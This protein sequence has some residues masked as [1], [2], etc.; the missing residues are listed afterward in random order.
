MSDISTLL[1][2]LKTTLAALTVTGG[3]KAFTQILPSIDDVTP[4]TFLSM[5]VAVIGN[6]AVNNDAENPEL[7][8]ELVWIDI[9]TRD[10]ST[11]G[12]KQQ[13]LG[14]R[15]CNDLIQIVRTAVAHKADGAW[16]AGFRVSGISQPAKRDVP[17]QGFVWNGRV[18]GT[19]I[20]G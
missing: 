15:G 14:Q 20:K 4:E 19:V 2:E 16:M 5:P 10:A 17:Q 9:W 8:T 1:D 3:G 7:G 11:Q 13:L 6:K 18:T 12:G